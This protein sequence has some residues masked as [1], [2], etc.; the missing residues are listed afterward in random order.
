MI[1]IL[2]D[3]RK[4]ESYAKYLPKKVD[5]IYQDVAQKDQARILEINAEMYQVSG[6]GSMLALKSQSI[7]AARNPKEVYEETANALARKFKIE[8]TVKLEPY[9][10][11]HMFYSLAKL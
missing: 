10:L 6:S 5:V 4:P 9:D 7:D 1:P 8:Q 3:A 11:D 2:A